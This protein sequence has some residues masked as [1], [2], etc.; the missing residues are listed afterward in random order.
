MEMKDM[1]ATLVKSLVDESDQ[2]D[3]KETT[4]EKITLYEVK[5]AKSDIGK[6]IGRNGR[7]IEALRVIISA[8]GAKRKQRCNFQIVDDES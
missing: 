6:V 2:V 1:V 7:T 3:V 4:G 8:C 5:V